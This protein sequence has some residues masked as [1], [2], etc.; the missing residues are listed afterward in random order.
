M[1]SPCP[2]PAAWFSALCRVLWHPWLSLHRTV[3]F[4]TAGWQEGHRG[5]GRRGGTRALPAT[6]QSELGLAGKQEVGGRHPCRR[7]EGDKP[8]PKVTGR[9]AATRIGGTSLQ[10]ARCSPG[11]RSPRPGVSEGSSERSEGDAPGPGYNRPWGH[12]SDGGVAPKPSADSGVSRPK[13]PISQRSPLVSPDSNSA[14][15]SQPL[16]KLLR[17][18]QL[19]L[20]LLLGR[21]ACL[22]PQGR[23]GLTQPACGRRDSAGEPAVRAARRGHCAG[24]PDSHPAAAP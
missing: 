10:R 2:I 20:D 16:E 7:P 17:G 12:T 13:P 21:W 19:P 5:R 14:S 1:N 22:G 8:A 9:G 24:L 15:K 3:R 18:E 4:P 6:E 23:R 11:S